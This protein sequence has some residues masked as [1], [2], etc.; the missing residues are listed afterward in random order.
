[1]FVVDNVCLGNKKIVKP[2]QVVSNERKIS[3]KL[4][5]GNL[6]LAY[7]ENDLKNIFADYNTISVKL[8][9]DRETGKS[10]GFGFIEFDNK[11][12]GLKAIQELNGKD[13]DGRALV[14]NEAR[15]QQ[16]RREKSDGFFRRRF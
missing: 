3:M 5:V 16:K 15:P 9:V 2:K 1:L 7:E 13:C 10:R 14:V 12:D 8:I 6:P 4:Y 11:E